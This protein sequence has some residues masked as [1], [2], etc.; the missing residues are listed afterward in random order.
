M[1]TFRERLA[2]LSPEKQKLLLS[3][4]QK[5]KK[6]ELS[7]ERILPRTR[8]NGANSFALSYPQQRMFTIA[9]LMPGDTSY[10]VPLHFRLQGKLN[11][12][13]LKHS[14]KQIAQKHE[15]LRTTFH[16][17]AGESK[18]V[19]S[20][21]LTVDVPV[22]D[23]QDLSPEKQ[24]AEVQRL[25]K[26]D[27]QCPFDLAKLPLWRV[28][29]LK[30]AEKNH[31]LLLNIHH[32]IFDGW[33]VGVFIRELKD[34]YEAYLAQK[35]PVRE[36]L[37]IQYVDYALWQKERLQGEFLSSKLEYWQQQLQGIS[38]LQLP[39]KISSQSETTGGTIVPLGFSETLSAQLKQLNLREGTTSN[40]LLLTAFFI[41]LGRYSNQDD[42]AVGSVIANR[43]S[44]ELEPLI[45][46]FVNTLVLRVDLSDN[47]KFIDLLAKVKTIVL[48]GYEHRE[49]PFDLLVDKLN[50]QREVQQNPLVQV[51][52]AFQNAPIPVF[53]MG[54][55]CIESIEVDNV[56]SN[57]R[58]DLELHLWE[59]HKGIEGVL[60]YKQERFNATAIASMASHYRTLLEAIV[61]APSQGIK[62]LPI[63]TEA[64]QR[65][66]LV[67]WNNTSKDYLSDRCI[68]QLFE[69]QVEKT[70]D[71]VAVI[72]R[73]E[74]LTY[75]QINKKAN[76]LAHYLLKLELSPETLIGLYL[77]PV[78][79]TIIALLA[80][81]KAGKAYQ[82]IEAIN[83]SENLNSISLILTQY[84]L[85][86]Q[87]PQ[88]RAQILCLDTD[89]EIIAQQTTQNPN[90][91]TAA[92]NLAYILNHTL[93]E[94]RSLTQRL[95]S[96]QETLNLTSQDILLHKA[97]LTEEIA[98]AEIGLPLLT[99]GK[100]VIASTNDPTELQKL[101][102]QHK[103]T[104]A[105]LY[106]SELSSW[107]N[108]SNPKGVLNS[109]HS[110]LC[111]G[112]ILLTELANIFIKTFNVS[113]H[114]FYSLPEAAG[115]ITHFQWEEKPLTKNVPVGTPC[116]LFVYLLDQEKQP[117]PME[118]LGE[119]YVGG[120][121]LARGYLHQQE[122]I[123]QKFIEHPHLGR[124]FRT[125]DL[126]R[127]HNNGYLEIVGAK[128]RHVW[129]TGKRVQLTDIETALLS[130]TG[131]E[132]AYV[133]A[134][135]TF[136]VAYV[137]VA[138]LWKPQQL[139]S[140][141]EQQLP[142]Y[143]MPGAYVPLSSLP[144]TQKGKVDELAL[145]R[146]PVIDDDLVQRWEAQLRALPEIEQVAVVVQQKTPH[147][148]PLH[149]SDLLPLEQITL[150]DNSATP[151]VEQLASNVQLQTSATS[152][153]L[154]ISAGEPLQWPEN[155]PITLAQTLE[156][157]AQQHADTNLIYIQPDGEMITQTYSELWVEAQRI[158]GG[159]RQLGL[160][161]QDKVI[162]QL[163]QNQD[164]ISAFWG[165][166][167]GGFVPVPV[168]I[169]PSYDQSHSTLTKLQ[170]TWQMLG[171]PLVLT[172]DKLASSVRRWSQRLNLEDFVVETLDG[173]RSFEPDRQIYESQ[174]QDLA[175]LLLTSGSTGKPKA[176][177]QE[178]RNLLSMSAGTIAMNQFSSQDVTLN[179]MPM[180]HVG[181]LVFLSMMAVDLGCQQIH[182]PTAFILQNPLQWLDLI[183]CH[184][185][186]I[187]WAP[188]FAFT[189]ISD[190]AEEIAKGHW[191]LS[192]MKF[193]VNAGEAIVTKT[194]RNFLKLLNH[195]GLSSKAIH[196]AFG[197]CET[198]S[199]ITWS[200]SFSFES[201]LDE[202]KFVELGQPISGACLRIVDANQQVVPEGVV[203]SLQV[204]GASVTSGYYQNPVANAEAFTKDGW[205]NTG[206]LGFLQNGHLTITGRQKDVI[207]INGLNYYSHEIEAAVEEL[208][209]IEVSYTA[210]CTVREANSNT[211]KLALFFNTEA[212][213][214]A[215]LLDLLKK[216]RE[217][218]VNH[219]GINPDFLI[220]LDKDLIPKTAIGK[221]QRTQLSQKFAAGEFQ[222]I[223][224]QVDL[225]TENNRT[226]PDWFYRK[227]WRQKK[228][229]DQLANIA[230]IG[231]I[232]IFFD[233][234][235]LAKKIC[236]K[237][238]NSSHRYIQVKSG[239][240]FTKVNTHQYII[241]PDNWE[242]YQHL[243]Q[244]LVAD[245][246]LIRAIIHLW[247]FDEYQR[248]I[249]DAESLETVQ[250]TG[251]Y[252][253]LFILQ[254][255][256][257]Q[258][259]DYPV[260]LLYVASHSQ[261]LNP[262]E[263]TAYA[264]ATVPGFLKTI[265]QEM[266]HWY[267]RHI[268][269]PLESL[270][271]NST[272]ILEELTI[273]AKDSE[274]AY[275][276]GERWV[277]GL[278]KLNLPSLPKQAL[279]FKT[280]G[281]YLISGGLGGVGVE[282]AKYL[283]QH[284]QAKLLLLG[285]TPLPE[286]DC[287]ET[288]LQQGGKVAE[289]LLAYQQL[290]QLS[291]EVVYQAV[292]ICNVTQVQ[293]VVQQTLSQ[294]HAQQLDG[295]IHLA[296]LMQ[297]RLLMEETPESFA[298]VL[299]PKL[300]GI[301]V[302]HQLVEKH[303]HSL[304]INFSS[305]NGFFGGT[306]VGAYAAAN[307]F[308]ESFSHYQR[309]QDK[310]DSYCFAWS[311]WDELGMS[312][313]YQMKQLS[314]AKGYLAVGLS[315]G[316]SSLLAGLCHNQPYL[317][318]GLDGSHLSI[319]SFTAPSDS[320]QQLTAYFTTNGQGKPDVSFLE[321]Q[322][323]D[324]L[325]KPSRCA[326]VELPEMPLTERG[327]IDVDLLSQS[328]FGSSIQER[329]QP[330]NELERKIAQI[331]REVLGVSK[332]GVYD[333]FF[334]LGG[335]SL[336][337][338]RLMNYLEKE[339]GNSLLL[340]NLFQYPTIEQLAA[341]LIEESRSSFSPVF[342]INSNG[343]KVPIFG[344]H[345][346]GGTAFCYFELAQLLGPEQPFY[347]LQALGIEKGQE[348]LTRVEDMA[349]LYLS[350][351]REVHPNGPYI[352]IGWSF[353]GLVA[354]QMAYELINKGEQVAF[355]GLLDTCAPS[356]L[357]DE[358]NLV[359]G[360]K[361]VFQLL[362]GT[363][364]VATEEFK[365]LTPEDGIAFILEK[366]QQANVVPADFEV[367]DLERLLEVLRVNYTAAH[368]YSPPNYPGSMT[369]FRAEK[370][371]IGLSLEIISAMGATLGW[372]EEAIA[373]VE[374]QTIPGYHEYM[375]YQ[376]DITALAQ[377]LQACLGQSLN[378]GKLNLTY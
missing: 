321:H 74:Q 22:I 49:V 100:L 350:A 146:F 30:L 142:P 339:F 48:E 62:Q 72:F 38:P 305:I 273:D 124:L 69:S 172:D 179:W 109:W 250:T 99:G 251:I 373:Q 181:A 6:K 245:N 278:E 311:M 89:W 34:F 11:T 235:G 173:L 345:P 349:N 25:L 92:T 154:A 232:L 106:P 296:G 206:D 155:R 183:D 330:R 126:G 309:Y 16:L 368:N 318:V 369:L 247:H 88:H 166:V 15:I 194:A 234:L 70:P 280:G 375:L 107:L 17:E 371:S 288:N 98:L 298:R 182:V 144:L 119:I 219:I 60:V 200:N 168:S 64:E 153:K 139:H 195:Y 261:S 303:P 129:I 240:S 36:Q 351:I 222:N 186:T 360:E 46:F 308:L 61:V 201:S 230:N 370:G 342:P 301:W 5:Q 27:T 197:M 28:N 343:S 131:V 332:I 237:L 243:Y 271:V 347:G 52:F 120:S 259:P 312:R 334:E 42:V 363:I 152:G 165:C 75:S 192:S 51:G 299:H 37:P 242:H 202:D 276:D 167:L 213:E 7:E 295:V 35:N 90:T 357:P 285:R 77:D 113:L 365:K 253:L 302:L 376:P 297:E 217:Q 3:Q 304:F 156:R 24:E 294:W 300:L 85:K 337:A 221:I 378:N 130:A 355:L 29:L 325:G 333:N 238:D 323:P 175:V 352:L 258:S 143:M 346:A 220:P 39:S 177:M 246:L 372:S 205:F 161:A 338:V 180:D 87:L 160:K 248:E 283:L 159:L 19:I 145:A 50:P 292:D 58:F 135:Q 354:L 193:L 216:L 252:S 121:S 239:E 31:I 277:S 291:D 362:G 45:G 264:K 236:H 47:P 141:L 229:E 91:A 76:Q 348:P 4:L 293:Q 210:A 54:E 73:D 207:I 9:Q 97:S 320:L 174:P 136:L 256:G 244:S 80:L 272:R 209:G 188:N 255:F 79:E 55:L 241:A 215:G 112:E 366:A 116:R 227:V 328:S 81:F 254:T 214:D 13:S 164:F 66:L 95:Q 267:C 262:Q 326:V 150:P 169:P 313:G 374:V 268:D 269:L 310:L 125:G 93:V 249:A 279:P 329:V 324:A 115:E 149:L 122:Q 111:S 274:V 317:M 287:W 84:H 196:P 198:C 340:S 41:L 110:L 281:T 327:E 266:P 359:E 335:N 8:E 57:A 290:Q 184:Q 118:V 178:H 33:S 319:R 284:Y 322:I 83:P 78:P 208:E 204:K 101:I 82:P 147:L 86:L 56:L 315:Q 218:V 137:V 105:H 212:T 203:G 190:R 12:T 65:K 134:H 344:I 361:M 123:S 102:A 367:A 68:H 133:L 63:M 94:H 32:I 199:G 117:V 20:S 104:I 187:S 127:R 170:N 289:K 151:V 10:S 307:S 306:M 270:E 336:L 71:A 14:L 18:Q 21:E 26:E 158:L 263:P 157:A 163:E 331:W 364:S 53:K 356:K 286:K 226:I 2:K 171:Q 44:K 162:F 59:G 228:G 185:A 23:L 225:I 138:G 189:L 43:N 341:L 275:R 176:V 40:I 353:G 314:Q 132:Q 231:V 128:Q 108:T 224:K 233:N 148:P 358:Q 265:P 96:L 316:M 260:R 282:I 223:L 114:N 1:S 103:I 140:Y 377:K 211:D 257:N 191:D 67:E